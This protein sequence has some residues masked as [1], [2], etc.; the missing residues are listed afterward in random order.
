MFGACAFWGLMAPLGK[1]AMAHG[2]TGV[3]MVAFRLLGAAVLFWTASL[4]V[5]SEP[6]SK[7][8]IGLF[9]IAGIFGLL[10]NQCCFTIGLS[11]TSPINAS[12]VTTSLPVFA[13]IAAALILGE[14]VTAK[15]VGGVL[16]GALGAVMLVLTSAHSGG[17]RGGDFVG[18]LLCLGAQCSFAL[19][20]SL[21]RSLIS[22]HSVI[23]INKWMFL[24]AS[25]Y[26]LPF[27]APSVAKVEWVALSL[28]T[29]LEIAYV[30]G[31]GTFVC[32]ILMMIG[33]HSLRP[34]VVSAYN[35][36]QP[37][38][39]VVVSVLT[40]IGVLKWQHAVASVLVFVGVW[41]INKSRAKAA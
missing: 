3:D 16:L 33:Q 17:G 14:P 15:K 27:A 26:A 25:L 29:W 28:V 19:Y 30:V 21:F 39:A 5:K 10:C 2:I 8:D 35:Y 6:V 31:F 23:T 36:V 20:L 40:G 12:I 34:T 13:M 41:L 37:M 7:G 4:F 24:F 38:V 11:M 22:R 9:S 32:Y 18:D 1:D